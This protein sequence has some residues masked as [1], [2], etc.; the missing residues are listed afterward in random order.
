MTCGEILTELEKVM[1][2]SLAME[3]DNPGLLIGDSDSSVKK[4]VIALD[5]STEVVNLAVREAADLVITHH[6]ILFSPLKK[7][8]ADDITGRRVIRLIEHHISCIA[9]HTN[10]DIAPGCM[11]DLAAGKLGISGDPLEETG[12]IEGKKIGIGKTGDLPKEMTLDALAEFVKAQFGL[13]YVAIFGRNR[14]TGPVRRIAVCPGS[15]RGMYPFAVRQGARVLITGDI[16]HHEGLDA[17]EAGIAVMDAGHYGLEHIFTEDM[18]K[19]M[20]ALKEGIE[21]L[22]NKVSFPEEVL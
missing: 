1:P 20:E 22:T 3:W 11:A 19:R 12:E 2:L 8:T 14:I 16:T 15:G 7:I 18:A 21:V 4:V 10:Y 6:P 9:M 13:P 5:L 17:A